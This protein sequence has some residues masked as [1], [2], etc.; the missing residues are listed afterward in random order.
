MAAHGVYDYLIFAFQAT[1]VTSGIALLLW[2][3]VIWRAH[4][5]L[6]PAKSALP[7]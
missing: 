3:F 4:R 7:N 5:C 1:F 6:K 2:L